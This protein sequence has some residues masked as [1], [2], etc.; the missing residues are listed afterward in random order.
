MYFFK[1]TRPAELNSKSRVELGIS[2]NPGMP[3]TPM[4]IQVVP[5]KRRASSIKHQRVCYNCI[6]QTLLS[7]SV[8]VALLGNTLNVL[9]QKCKVD[10]GAL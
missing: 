6:W 8:K 3:R 2:L 10:R 5:N 7:P 1:N 9:F 4:K